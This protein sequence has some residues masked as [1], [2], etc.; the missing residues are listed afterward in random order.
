MSF[1]YS[2]SC[3][4]NISKD[5]CSLNEPALFI[6]TVS[7]YIS[8]LVTKLREWHIGNFLI[9]RADLKNDFRLSYS[10]TADLWGENKPLQKSTVGRYWTW[11]SVFF[12][13]WVVDNFWMASGCKWKG[14]ILFWHL[15]T[16]P[17]RGTRVLMF[18]CSCREQSYVPMSRRVNAFLS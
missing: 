1:Y 4:I 3:V 7:P 13:G 11:D 6:K 16:W 14:A 12:G 10:H 18:S 9:L 5:N 17:L 8:C 15:E 2:E